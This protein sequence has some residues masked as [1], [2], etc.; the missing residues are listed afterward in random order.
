MKKRRGPHTTV[1]D[2]QLIR[3]R[4]SLVTA[5]E[6]YW[7]EIGWEL[8][9]CKKET[10]LINAL[11]PL[12]EISFIPEFTSIVLQE[13]SGRS[14][15][16]EL[17]KV[18]AELMRVQESCDNM[19]EKRSR[20]EELVGRLT[21]ALAQYP[22][23]TRSIEVKQFIGRIEARAWQ[24]QLY[25]L[26][27]QKEEVLG[28]LREHE[29]K[30]ARQ[31]IFLFCNRKRYAMTP[32]HLANASAGLPHI[33]WRQSM[34]RIL[35]LQIA[36]PEGTDYEIFKAIRFMTKDVKRSS[37]HSL[38]AEFYEAIPKLP[39]RYRAARD[40][41]LC[42]SHLLKIAL[43]HA[44]REQP[45]GRALPFEISKQYFRQKRSRTPYDRMLV[46]ES[47]PEPFRR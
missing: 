28:R 39:N 40:E 11:A 47:K 21:T 32:L 8:Q 46:E 42:E 45:L 25:E 2:D 10:D 9:K 27:Q 24:Q 35:K 41:L 26:M 36:M 38:V 44:L 14:S 4:A 13:S 22:D 43:Q 20:A 31:E 6:G 29:G 37:K 19:V 15:A 7:G 23:K 3:R 12:S 30:F 18:R 5:F 34:L 33:G 17:R 16:A 1:S